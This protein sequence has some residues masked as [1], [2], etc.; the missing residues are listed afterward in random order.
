MSNTTMENALL[1]AG[2]VTTA[3]T[4]AGRRRAA[5]RRVARVNRDALIRALFSARDGLAKARR[6]KRS[7]VAAKEQIG[8]VQAKLVAAVLT[9][10]G[11]V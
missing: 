5:A 9:L 7:Q 6:G 11:L 2:I 8:L 10:R 1:S 4:T 3:Q